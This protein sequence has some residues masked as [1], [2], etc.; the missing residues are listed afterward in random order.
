MKSKANRG[1]CDFSAGSLMQGHFHVMNH[2]EVPMP[3]LSAAFKTG[4]LNLP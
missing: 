2:E 1:T 3:G 4:Y